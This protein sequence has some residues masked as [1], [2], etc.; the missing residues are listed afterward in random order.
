MSVEALLKTKIED[1]KEPSPLPSGEWEL[2][3]G[4][5]GFKDNDDYDA[6]Q[7]ADKF[8]NPKGRVYFQ[9]VPVKPVSNVDKDAVKDGSW[10][11]RSTSISIPIV[12]NDDLY[13]VS[14][15][16]TGLGISTDGRD[17]VDA[18]SLAKNRNTI[19]SVGLRV[20]KKDGRHFTTLTDFRPPA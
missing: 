13:E 2:R 19:A 4:G 9:F 15:V 7:P 8:T 3:C 10:R 12:G 14:K 11:G 20:S 17:Y 18:L 1:V 5:A 6:D 16:L